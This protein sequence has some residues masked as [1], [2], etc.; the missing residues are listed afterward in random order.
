MITDAER[1]GDDGKRGVH[2]AAR[3]EE[4]C[5]D[6]IEVVELV[7]LAIAIERTRFRI[8]AESDGAVLMRNSGERNALAEKQIPCEQAF[9]AL[10]SVN[11]AFG[12]LLHE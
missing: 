2:R 9:V 5:I 3:T 7:R 11:R 8:V 12:L 1:V 6:N 10:M 4:T